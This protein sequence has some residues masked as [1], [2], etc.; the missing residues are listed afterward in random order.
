MTDFERTLVVIGLIRGKLE[1]K[2]RFSVVG[3][4]IRLVLNFSPPVSP[5]RKKSIRWILLPDFLKTLPIT[6]W[7][8]I[9]KV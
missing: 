7:A 2:F 4:K 6:Q 8:D 3:K 5:L 9:V 1:E